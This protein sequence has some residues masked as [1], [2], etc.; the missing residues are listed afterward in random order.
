MPKF[1]FPHF[2]RIKTARLVLYGGNSLLWAGLTLLF[3]LNVYAKINLAPAYEKQ[4]QL[5]LRRPFSR[6]TH[7]AL[8]HGFWQQGF[9][10]VAQTELRLAQSLPRENNISVL[11]ISTEDELTTWASEPEKA[12]AAYGFW[13][14][15]V[16]TRLDYRDAYLALAAAA[17]QLGYLDEAKMAAQKA[18]ALSPSTG[19]ITRLVELLG[20]TK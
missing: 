7:E 15:V 19:D 20:K 1:Q 17:Y 4:L 14:S 11:G 5:A 16:A 3:L 13:K 10:S 12:K 6:L 2:T 8:A 18:L 9:V